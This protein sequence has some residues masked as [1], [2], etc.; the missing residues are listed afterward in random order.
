MG[1][2]SL[3]R[4]LFKK[5]PDI[6]LAELK[7]GSID[8]FFIDFNCIIHNCKS[9]SIYD[10]VIIN[11][12]IR[13]TKELIDIV[14]PTKLVYIAMDGP[15]PMGKLV[16]QRERRYKKIYDDYNIQCI[17]HKFNVPYPQTFD[18][19]KISPG[20][21]FMHQLHDKLNEAISSNVFG[22]LQV[23]FS[24]SNRTG[25][26][27]FKIF[28]YIRNNHVKSTH[29]IYSMDADI[30]I[31]SMLIRKQNIYVFRHDENKQA[32]FIDISLCKK[33][34]ATFIDTKCEYYQRIVN[35][36]CFISLLGG[37]DFVEP[38]IQF[39]IRDSGWD[40]L[41]DIYTKY[42]VGNGF[43][44][45][46]NNNINVDNFEKFIFIANMYENAMVD[47]IKSKRITLKTCN[48]TLHD[49]IE[50]YHHGVMDIVDVID[51]KQ[52]N[53]YNEY[54][55]MYLDNNACMY[56]L[57]SIKWCWS[58]Y[59]GKVISWSFY[60]HYHHAPTIKK[61]YLQIS[62][63]NKFTFENS[64]CM[65]PVEQL[66]VILPSYSHYLLPIKLQTI[67]KKFP[68]MYPL[69][70]DFLYD[71]KMIYS[72]PLLPPIRFDKAFQYY[73]KKNHSTSS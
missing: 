58:Y 69:Q 20:T 36:I 11:E 68:Y 59:H 9:V 54:H 71:K 2:P 4:T 23:I 72:I 12:V 42:R 44:I 73:I 47:K 70:F 29:C 43:L 67:S 22:N 15:V 10:Q 63:L 17:Y 24:D 32:Q 25:E 7:T 28:E 33:Q 66:C 56:Y 18:S 57:K 41:I 3:F 1:V 61:I 65:N 34:I 13:Y 19:N 8:C 62:L 30:L 60:Y 53:W 5:H 38:I 40:N 51:Y 46:L 49:C 31:L 55:D 14:S 45:E 48:Q 26:G 35:D 52:N 21:S 37:N 64:T 39:K 16:R 50:H 27:E 6:V